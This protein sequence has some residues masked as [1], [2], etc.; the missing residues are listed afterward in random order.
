MFLILIISLKKRFEIS[1]PGPAKFNKSAL[2]I[3][4]LIPRKNNKN[5]EY[6]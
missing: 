1:L 3:F 5:N 6:I 4:S 2:K